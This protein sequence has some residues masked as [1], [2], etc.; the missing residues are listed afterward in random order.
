[1]AFYVSGNTTVPKDFKSAITAISLG[2]IGA[3]SN[4][5]N[6]GGYNL[7]EPVTKEGAFTV[8]DYTTTVSLQCAYGQLDS[9][10]F[11]GQASVASKLDCQAYEE[12]EDYE[13]PIYP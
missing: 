12:T 4:A 1:M 8:I 9:L 2:N 6:F 3:S 10:K 13:F 11:F 5:C 7:K